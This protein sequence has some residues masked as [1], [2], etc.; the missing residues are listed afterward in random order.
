MLKLNRSKALVRIVLSYL[1]GFAI[2]VSTR[3][4]APQYGLLMMCIV[5]PILMFYPPYVM[6]HYGQLR[7]GQRPT[8]I[9][10]SCLAY[11]LHLEF[12]AWFS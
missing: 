8:S 11:S 6:Y 4:L 2:F 3:E 5:L 9:I 10:G 7:K 12:L 1:V